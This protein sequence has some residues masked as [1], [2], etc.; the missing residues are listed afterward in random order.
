MFFVDGVLLNLRLPE[1]EA[2][3]FL[4][5][6]GGGVADTLL[7][8]S[9]PG[10][11]GFTRFSTSEKRAKTASNSHETAWKSNEIHGEILCCS[12]IVFR[13][14]VYRMAFFCLAYAA[15]LGDA[16]EAAE[17]PERKEALKILAHQ[18]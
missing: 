11:R 8:A 10:I 14:D 9:V 1:A 17:P 5:G 3:I 4:G 12:T 6:G 18:E 13:D 7:T 16:D 15:R 2:P